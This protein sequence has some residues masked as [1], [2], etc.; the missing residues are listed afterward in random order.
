MIRVAFLALRVAFFV[1]RIALLIAVLGSG[2]H[3]LCLRLPFLARRASFLG[4]RYYRVG[5]PFI[6]LR[7]TLIAPRGR[8]PCIF[9]CPINACAV[10]LS[11]LRA[12]TFSGYLT[13]DV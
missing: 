1:L 12:A 2:L 11:V 6:V 10:A 13:K 8:C 4:F 7:I 3:S 5:L 9:F